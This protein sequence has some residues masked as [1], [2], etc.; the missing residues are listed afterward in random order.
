VEVT[1]RLPRIIYGASVTAWLTLAAL[2][3]IT[4]LSYTDRYVFS[5]LANSVRVDLGLSDSQLGLIQGATFAFSYSAAALVLIRWADALPGRALLLVGLVI[6]SAGT[7]LSGLSHSFATL[8]VARM[9]VGLGEAALFPATV[10]MVS[11]LFPPQ[12]RGFAISVLIIGSIAASGVALI[13]SG[14]LLQLFQSLPATARFGIAEASSWRVVLIL[15]GAPAILAAPLI[16]LIPSSAQG[17]IVTAESS[18]AAK[19]RAAEH[20]TSQSARRSIL[21]FL[22]AGMTLW[23]LVDYGLNAWLA[24]ALMRTFR[25]TP[26]EIA[27][28]LGVASTIAGSVGPLAGGFI[29]DWLHSAR[30]RAGRTLV[31]V[32]AIFLATPLTL[33]SLAPSMMLNVMLFSFYTFLTAVAFTVAVAALQ[34]AALPSFRG[35]AMALQGFLC[36]AVGMGVGPFAVARLSDFLAVDG[37]RLAVALAAI[38]TPTLS[39]AAILFVFAWLRSRGAPE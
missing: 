23:A 2:F 15:L 9:L 10:P 17:D 16:L 28:Q 20:R 22:L 34:E 38:S 24:S 4:I 19:V 26:G 5:V 31:C 27:G 35:R 30:V 6:W 36:T 13:V 11:R 18:D 32:L 14:T 1:Q 12:R 39:V 37:S 29:A 7:L 33:L 21:A 3:A 25:A 8:S